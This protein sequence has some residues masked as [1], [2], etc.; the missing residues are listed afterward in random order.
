MSLTDIIYYLLTQGFY[1]K[2][3][4][5]LVSNLNYFY[6]YLEYVDLQHYIQIKRLFRK[7]INIVEEIEEKLSKKEIGEE[8]LNI[9]KDNPDL[10]ELDWKEFYSI[11]STMDQFKSY[12]LEF[13]ESAANYAGYQKERL[14]NFYNSEICTK[15]KR[16]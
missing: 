13:L 7:N 15:K 1:Q 10:I 12:S 14:L 2:D 16:L 8:I 11:L 9:I 3:K 5:F 6:L 4:Y